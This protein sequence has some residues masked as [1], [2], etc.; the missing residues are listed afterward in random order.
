MLTSPPF[1]GRMSL[2]ELVEQTLQ[3]KVHALSDETST[4][5]KEL[6]AAAKSGDDKAALAREASAGAEKLVAE[7]S[8]AGGDLADPHD[9]KRALS[10]LAADLAALR[11]EAERAAAGGGFG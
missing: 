5:R 8:W 2:R 1:F 3:D 9:F 7:L 4:L 10:R 6:D 11:S